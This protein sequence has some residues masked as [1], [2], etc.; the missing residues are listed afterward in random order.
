MNKLVRLFDE[1]IDHFDDHFICD[2][3]INGLFVC[4]QIMLLT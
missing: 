4:N 2:E 3:L 1:H